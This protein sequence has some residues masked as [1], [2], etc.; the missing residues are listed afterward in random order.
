[1]SKHNIIRAWKDPNY[2]NSLSEAERASLPPNPAGA[3][4]ISDADLGK[5]AGSV[6]DCITTLQPISAD[7]YSINHVL[8]VDV[9]WTK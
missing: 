6:A 7:C 4:E 5:V 8:S 2:R 9:C 3:I 1:M